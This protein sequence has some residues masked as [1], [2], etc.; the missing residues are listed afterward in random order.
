VAKHR[1]LQLWRD[2]MHG[3]GV[4]P[5]GRP[6]WEALNCADAWSMPDDHTVLGLTV[7]Y[8]LET[9][10]AAPAPWPRDERTPAPLALAAYWQ[11]RAED[12]AGHLPALRRLLGPCIE[13]GRHQRALAAAEA[14][15]S[16]EW[17]LLDGVAAHDGGTATVPAA[18]RE[19]ALSDRCAHA[20]RTRLIPPP[21]TP[22]QRRALVLDAVGAEQIVRGE[23]N[24]EMDGMPA[25]AAIT[26][27][28]FWV[29]AAGPDRSGMGA[30]AI[31]AIVSVELRTSGRYGHVT[32]GTV[33]ARIELKPGD[34]PPGGSSTR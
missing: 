30:P 10:H 25:V 27:H 23:Y 31:A 11:R 7:L 28:S 4:E 24:V 21:T 18:G 5:D 19:A 29:I 14:A 1:Q 9:A 34:A 20:A 32:V 2:L 13:T 33:V 22:W 12:A 17:A 8:T 26:D 16:A 3:V 15:V 6:A